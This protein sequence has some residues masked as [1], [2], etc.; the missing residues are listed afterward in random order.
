MEALMDR[1]FWISGVVM[2]VLAFAF[3]FVVHGLLL[4]GDYAPLAGSVYRTPEDAQGYFPYMALAHVLFGFAFT[5]IYRQGK[6]AG[7]STLGQ[8][9][10]FGLAVAALATIPTCLIYYA[11]QPTPGALA[12]KQILFGTIAVVLMGIAVAYLNRA[13]GEA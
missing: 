2:S 13:P 5:W 12:A 8:G 9:V 10:R 11:V 6:T 7:A 3:G 4:G 1:K